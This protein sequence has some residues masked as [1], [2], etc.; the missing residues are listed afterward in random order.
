MKTDFFIL[1]ATMST[2]TIDKWNKLETQIG[3]RCDSIED[4]VQSNVNDKLDLD[5]LAERTKEKIENIKAKNAEE[6]QK[7]EES[8]TLQYNKEVQKIKQRTNRKVSVFEQ[9]MDITTRNIVSDETIRESFLL[10][11]GQL[12]V[13]SI[14][15]KVVVMYTFLEMLNTTKM[16]NVN[17]AYIE[18]ILKNM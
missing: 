12:D 17:E 2:S 15:D 3:H 10:E 9:I 1:T 16:A 8:Y 4:F 18:N 7:I 13:S 6:R 14:K 11:S 5:E